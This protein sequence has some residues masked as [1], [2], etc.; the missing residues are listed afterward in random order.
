MT[1]TS[2]SWRAAV[3]RVPG[4]ELEIIRV[5]R[6]EL[7]WG[8]VLVQVKFSGVCRSQLMEVRGQRGHDADAQGE[9]ESAGEARHRDG[10]EQGEDERR[11]PVPGGRQRDDVEH[12]VP[13]LRCSARFSAN[14][15]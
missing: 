5:Q 14:N 7:A 15:A 9:A 1:D 13:G 8:Q 4:Q 3:L 11:L 12:Q 6:P 2:A 10:G